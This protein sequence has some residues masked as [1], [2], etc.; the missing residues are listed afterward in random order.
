[1]SQ[2]G[3]FGKTPHRGDFVRF[4]L[5][6]SFITVW[7]DWLQQ[8]MISG[9]SLGNTWPAL[10]A[11]TPAYRFALSGGIAGSTPWLGLLRASQD[12]VGRRFPFCLAMSLS[13]DALAI[14]SAIKNSH[15]YE[16]AENLLDR[17]LESEYEFDDLQ[18]ELE[19]LALRHNQAAFEKH[20]LQAAVSEPS[21]DAVTISMATSIKSNT[22]EN[23]P[24]LLDAIL[25]QTLGEYS[26]WVANG[27]TANTVINS[28]LPVGPAGLALVKSNWPEVSTVIVD[29]NQ[30]TTTCAEHEPASGDTVPHNLSH[31]TLQNPT[32]PVAIADDEVFTSTQ[33]TSALSQEEQHTDNN[34]EPAT[35][36]QN[37]S[38]DDWAAL[39][40]FTNTTQ[41]SNGTI[42]PKIEPLELEEDDVSNAPWEE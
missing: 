2:L 12:K 27:D 24:A 35:T 40:D 21:T 23:T 32:K 4:N 22:V 17:V 34:S 33:P 31:N 42:V 3:Y 16:D 9:E 15:F 20:N 7:D 28:G 36:E 25:Q 37:P 29:S 26:L 1:M 19:Q 38:A 5:P 41:P 8:I 39:D 13:P 10:Y 6:Q 11:N 18:D 14:T 30:P